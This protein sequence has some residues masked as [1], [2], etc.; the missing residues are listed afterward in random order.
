VV[1]MKVDSSP[2]GRKNNYVRMWPRYLARSQGVELN[3]YMWYLTL[4]GSEALVMEVFRS[5][6]SAIV[7][8]NRDKCTLQA[9]HPSYLQYPPSVTAMFPIVPVAI[10]SSRPS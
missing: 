2:A 4:M 6:I 7:K 8:G 1:L 5:L 3:M 10:P 9:V